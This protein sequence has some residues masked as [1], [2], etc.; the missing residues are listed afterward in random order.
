MGKDVV[1]MEAA[2][3]KPG[4]DTRTQKEAVRDLLRRATLVAVRTPLFVFNCRHLF[5]FMN[6]LSSTG[7]FFY[8][9]L[10][11]MATDGFRALAVQVQ[12]H[13]H[14]TSADFTPGLCVVWLQPPRLLTVVE[15]AVRRSPWMQLLF[16]IIVQDEC[17]VACCSHSNAPLAG[18][19]VFYGLMVFLI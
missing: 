16:T 9:T 1:D 14:L 8:A 10:M 2:L 15:A 4:N 5:G 17:I 19:L 7:W 12:Q 11:L 6:L 13:E 3:R 18:P